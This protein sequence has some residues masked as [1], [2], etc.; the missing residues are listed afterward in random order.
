MHGAEDGHEGGGSER[1]PYQPAPQRVEPPLERRLLL[2]NGARERANSAEL[3]AVG[4]RGDEDPGRAGGDD[5]ALIDHVL[6]LGERGVRVETR[7]GGL[8]QRERL[9]VSAASLV[10]RSVSTNTRPSAGTACP[11]FNSMTSPG[12]S[13]S[14]SSAR[15][16]RPGRPA[17]AGLKLEQPS[18]AR[19]A[20]SSMAN[21]SPPLRR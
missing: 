11:A 10:R 6:A 19:R 9:S 12:T 13:R 20:R 1:Q 16:R 8:T 14:A 21:P 4:G 7:A 15:D 18:I 5:R 2:V 3:G 17:P